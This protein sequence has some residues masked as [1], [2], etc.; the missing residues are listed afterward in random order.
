MC[1]DLFFNNADVERV[2]KLKDLVIE[3][4]E[5]TIFFF[6]L[7]YFFVIVGIDTNKIMSQ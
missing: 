4:N 1:D 2:R 6:F 5:V 3:L 7:L